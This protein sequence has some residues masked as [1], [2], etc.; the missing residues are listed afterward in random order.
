MRAEAAR[1]KT[2]SRKPLTGF[3]GSRH[4]VLQLFILVAL[5]AGLYLALS[6]GLPP[7]KLKLGEPAP[8]DYVARLDFKFE[9]VDA[10]RRAR[11]RAALAAP[12]VVRRVQK[13]F[14][15]SAADVLDLLEK[16]ESSPA[17]EG[18]P[19]SL[20]TEELALALGSL[21]QSAPALKEALADLGSK[22]L[23]SSSIAESG[24]LG[25]AGHVL[26]Y[27]GPDAE[28]QKLPAEH[29]ITLSADVS[30]FREQ[31]A[32]VLESVEPRQAELI[33]KAMAEV[34]EPNLT[35]DADM[36]KEEA[37]KAAEAQPTV[38]ITVS[39]GAVL[40]RQ[41]QEVQKQHVREVT[42]ERR[43]YW[44]SSKG[45]TV[46]WQRLVG[47]LVLLLA[48]MLPGVFYA[49]HY[50]SGLLS[51]KLQLFSF[52]CCTLLFVG[53]ARLFVVSGI[54]LLLVPVPLVIMSLC[55]VFGQRIGFE[56]AVFYGLLI[57]LASYA[58][59]GDFIVLTLGGMMA[60]LLSGQVRT[61]S[62]LIKAGLLTGCL[63]WAAV[64]G[65]GLL[66]STGHSPF[67]LAFWPS[68]LFADSLAA[69][70]NGVMS[71]FL[72]S[73]LLPAIEKLFGVITDIRLLEW[74][75]P[76]QP[77]LQRLLLDAPGTYHHSMLVGSLAGDAAEA[78][79]ANPLLARVGAYFH[80]IGKL[81][82]PEYF[83]ENLPEDG[84]NPHDDLSPSMSHLIIS[85][86][87]K[88]GAEMAE[89]YG[90]PRQIRDIILESHGST[91]VKYFYDRAKGQKREGE[92]DPREETFRYHLPK[93]Q[94]KETAIILLCDAVESG[95]RSLGE[96]SPSRVRS[97]VHAVVLDK[98]HD[99]QLDESGLSITDLARIE[100]S[101]VHGLN[102]IFHNRIVYPGQE[103]PDRVDGGNEENASTDS[104]PTA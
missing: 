90:L 17:W 82:K 103:K 11:E 34:L 89:T 27:G 55:L 18:L 3:W 1:E 95:A 19:A 20:T 13:R 56:L 73:G 2:E 62:A 16:G 86:H 81:S 42:E 58:L 83:V 77:L 71:G 30:E 44:A 78:V 33:L 9:D 100:Q 84:K 98:L 53:M 65:L 31:F 50:Q 51:S 64:W 5:A 101:L 38:I 85:A 92:A 47:L 12:L 32:T 68:G 10:T 4:T 8:R 91:V 66:R 45:K 52:A 67:T 70:A 43:Q 41:G 94:S 26:L 102:A 60:A 35:V 93:P 72:V 61:R 76:N 46:R 88:D 104:Q 48:V 14:E 37:E 21:E 75:D 74:S 63:Q 87:P 54:P 25:A 23:V 69:L 28:L 99:G 24:R 97:L 96:P 49:K 39:E 15:D 57:S 22:T 6:A 7:L 29:L 36:S 59:G 80:D 79:G 40:L